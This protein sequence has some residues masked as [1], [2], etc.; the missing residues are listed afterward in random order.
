MERN[1]YTIRND[2]IPE[3]LNEIPQPPKLLNVVGNLPKPDSKILCVVGSRDYSSYG[4]EVCK[5]IVS[6]LRG[7]NICI[8]SGLARGIDGIAHRAA[9]DAGLQTVAFPGSG[10]NESIL[11]PKQH[12][13]LAD[14]IIYRGGGLVSE[15]DNNQRAQDWMFPQRNRLMAGISD[16]TLIIEAGMKSGTLITARL[17]LDYNRNVGIVPGSIFSKLSEGPHS[18]V[19]DGAMPITNSEDVL[20]LLDFNRPE[21]HAMQG[22]LLLDLNETEERIV[23]QLQI[24]ALNIEELVLR[25]ELSPR[26]INETISM[27][28]IRGI[29]EEKDGKFKLR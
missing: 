22:N 15:Y 17:A 20:E 23:D 28:E 25:L 13:R 24:E 11:Y 1:I 5:K 10:L 9:L 7:Y 14:E 29:V 2:E 27:L 18:L 6:G 12:R 3:K 4:E 16:A 21:G 19:R 26:D 8:V